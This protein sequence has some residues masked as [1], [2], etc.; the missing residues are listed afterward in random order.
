MFLPQTKATV[1]VG[2]G[3]TGVI[4]GLFGYSAKWCLYWRF[5]DC[6]KLLGYPLYK[7]Q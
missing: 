2:G 7:N 4:N 5:D 1:I 6:R 3:I